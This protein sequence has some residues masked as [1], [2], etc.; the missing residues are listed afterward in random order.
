M[1]FSHLEFDAMAFF[2]SGSWISFACKFISIHSAW[3]ESQFEIALLHNSL[4]RKCTF[5]VRKY[6]NNVWGLKCC[7]IHW[8]NT[9]WLFCQ[10]H[11]GHTYNVVH[12]A[13]SQF[14]SLSCF[15]KHFH[16]LFHHTFYSRSFLLR[17]FWQVGGSAAE[18]KKKHFSKTV[19]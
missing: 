8:I 9:F 5:A 14:H 13:Y 2:F 4:L 17:N 1:A 19:L 10:Q 18:R 11:K 3:Q 6:W 16:C 15:N 7:K 12:N